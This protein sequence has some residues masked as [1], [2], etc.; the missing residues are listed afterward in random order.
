MHMP[1]GWSVCSRTTPPMSTPCWMPKVTW[2]PPMRTETTCLP[3][4][5]NLADLEQADK[6]ADRHIGPKT[7]DIADMLAVLGVPSLDELIE[8]AV[9]VG[10]RC[11]PI[12]GL[13]GARSEHQA[14]ADSKA[15]AGLNQVKRSFIGMGYYGTL[16]PTVI[17]RNVLENPG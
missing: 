8:Q 3:E 15:L 16:T 17:L 13:T 2:P 10:I 14:L 11:T 5:A 1:R 7:D 12:A 6:F 4:S 9:P